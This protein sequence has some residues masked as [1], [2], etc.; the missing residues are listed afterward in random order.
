MM[1]EAVIAPP[2]ED[3]NSLVNVAAHLPRMAQLQPHMR[4]VV[5]PSGRDRS[6]LVT[7][8]HYT[9]KQLNETCDK[10]AHGLESVGIK[11]GTKTVLMV[12]PSLDFFA[13]TFALFKVGAVPVMID[14][15]MGIKRMLHCLKST[16][17][18]GFVG[19]SMAHAL[20]ILSPMILPGAFK[21]IN[22]VVTVG[23]RLFW[24]GATLKQFLDKP[25]TP[26]EM[27]PTEPEEVAA[28]L[29]T[30]GSTGP[31]KGVVYTHRIFN[32]QVGYMRSVFGFSPGDIDLPTFPLFALFAPALGMTAIVPDMDPTKPAQVDPRKII[33]AVENQGVTT[34]FGSPALLNRVGRYGEEHA[35]KFPSIRR[36]LTAG[37]PVAPDNLQRFR[38]LI[39]DDGEIYTPYGA[40]E[41]LPVAAMKSRDI[42]EETQKATAQGKG[43]CVGS[44]VDGM[45]ARIIRISDEAI[46]EWS[47]DLL[48]P[49]GD[50]GEIIVQGPTVTR[51]YYRRPDATALAKIVD[52]DTFWHRMGDVG[53]LDE[54][55][56]IWFCGRMKH[57]VQ[58]SDGPMFTIQCEAIFNQHPEV[59]RTALVGVGKAPDQTPVLLVE[60]EASASGNLDQLT[61]ELLDLGAQ[62]KHTSSIS[63]I[64][65]HPSFPVDIRHN[66]KIFREKLAIWAAEQIG[67]KG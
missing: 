47:D 57:R 59:Y 1:N 48:V 21:S 5:F 28:I 24:G 63:T 45:T 26:Y 8:S 22:S 42:L 37:A 10:I 66:A 64:L 33:E 65:Y 36:V 51:T 20:R 2:V 60:R 23:R 49:A 15:G 54:K 32:A 12:K 7:Y 53:W 4:A 25:W 11:R 17:P 31:A 3:L 38:N 35:I 50:I 52:G 46:P 67:V 27:A 6:G 44:P 29:F 16:E 19:I 40:T 56:R 58:T 62:H 61:Q 13:L 39:A 41:S 18:E 14:P 34:M 43:T 30:T 55:G 9:Y